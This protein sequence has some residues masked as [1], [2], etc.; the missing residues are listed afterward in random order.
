M[1]TIS[2]GQ[3]EAADISPTSEILT[4]ALGSSGGRRVTC[5]DTTGPSGKL[6]T[7]WQASSRRPEIDKSDVTSLLPLEL[8]LIIEGFGRLL[9]RSQT[10]FTNARKLTPR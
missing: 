5:Y 9:L 7:L 3:Y 1:R 8:D 4:T 6:R 10:K 2:V